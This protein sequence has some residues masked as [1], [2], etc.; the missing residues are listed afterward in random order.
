MYAF[1]QELLCWWCLAKPPPFGV[2]GRELLCG[3]WQPVPGRG[4]AHTMVLSA[5]RRRARPV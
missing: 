1:T 2:V 5:L 3:G 4:F